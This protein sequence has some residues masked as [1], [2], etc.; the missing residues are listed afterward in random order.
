VTAILTALR[1]RWTWIALGAV[2]VAGAG[3][4]AAGR[5]AAPVKT[6][7]T[8]RVEYRDRVVTQEVVREV[9]VAGPVR[10]QERIVERPG[11]ERVVERV[12]ERGPVTTT[13]D[14][15]SSSERTSSGTT[16][17]T[18]VVEARRPATALE[19]GASWAP[20][21]LQVRP[22]RV[23]A[24]LGRR[25]LGPVWLAVTAEAPVGQLGDLEAYRVGLR[26][27]VEW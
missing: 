2:V 22:E 11:A 23:D 3:G 5:Y 16:A 19:L 8:T 1:S 25:I 7:E 4:Y 10:I 20:S 24:A 6:V 27:R 13:T 17:T 26:A 15:A 21:H 14:A 9:R 12:I 18:R